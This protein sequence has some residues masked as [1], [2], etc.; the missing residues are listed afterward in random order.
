MCC[1]IH[2]FQ[3]YINGLYFGSKSGDVCY[4][5]LWYPQERWWRPH[6][7]EELIS[8]QTSQIQ[9]GRRLLYADLRA[10]S[11][12][13]VW[14]VYLKCS[15]RSTGGIGELWEVWPPLAVEQIHTVICVWDR[16]NTPLVNSTCMQSSTVTFSFTWTH[17]V[18]IGMKS[19]RLMNT[20]RVLTSGV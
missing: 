10:V 17:F 8:G 6:K 12:S 5:S 3:R 11:V 15:C 1:A 4:R 20:N 18:S 14:N 19:L 7:Q 9:R 2:F 16:Q 13:L